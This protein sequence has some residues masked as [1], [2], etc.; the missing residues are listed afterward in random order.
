MGWAIS[1]Q[2]FIRGPDSPQAAN[3]KSKASK[4]SEEAQEARDEA[5]ARSSSRHSHLWWISLEFHWDFIGILVGFWWD[6]IRIF[7]GLI[8]IILVGF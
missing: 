4:A 2:R 7:M 5:E 1:F 8:G 6:L 3:A